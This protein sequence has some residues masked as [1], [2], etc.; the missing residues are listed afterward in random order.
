M[1][2]DGHVTQWFG[3]GNNAG[4]QTETGF[5][6]S[7]NGSGPAGNIS[8][9]ANGHATTNNAGTTTSNFSNASVTC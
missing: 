9:H 7:Y 8:I 4:G 6:L 2:S 5:T 1:T 3:Q